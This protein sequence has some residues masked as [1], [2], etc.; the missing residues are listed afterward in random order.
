MNTYIFLYEEMALFE[1]VLASFFMK[2]KGTVKYVGE[3]KDIITTEEGFHVS[4]DVLFEDLDYEAID[5]FILPGG[6]IAN[7]NKQTE[8]KNLICLLNNKGKLIGGICA[9]MNLISEVLNIHRVSTTQGI[10][11]NIILAPGNEYVDFA[12]ELGKLAHIYE[13]EADL[14]ETINYFK[15]FMP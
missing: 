1:V 12:I 4:A 3:R 14:Q 11:K 9:G 8:L 10:G 15:K 2:E 13:D 5:V 6:Q 7:I